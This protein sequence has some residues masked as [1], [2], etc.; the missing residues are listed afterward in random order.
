MFDLTLEQ[1]FDTVVSD[2]E[3]VFESG[4]LGSRFWFLRG[5]STEFVTPDGYLRHRGE[6]LTQHA[7]FPDTPPGGTHTGR[8]RRNIVARQPYVPLR[9]LVIISIV[10]VAMF[11]LASSVHANGVPAETVTYQVSAGDTLWSIAEAHGGGGDVRGTVGVIQ[12][13][14]DLNGSVIQ[15]GQLLELP[16]G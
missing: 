7:G 5:E 16:A 10:V 13:L 8:E 14:N 4:G 9:A 2:L 6:I 15:A 3:Q 12:R 11:L 1:A